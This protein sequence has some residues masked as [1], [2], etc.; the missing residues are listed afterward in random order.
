MADRLIV[1]RVINPYGPKARDV[2]IIFSD[3]IRYLESTEW[4]LESLWHGAN[5]GYNVLILPP[6]IDNSHATTQT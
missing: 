4:D 3:H 1:A 6:E 5:E 2:K